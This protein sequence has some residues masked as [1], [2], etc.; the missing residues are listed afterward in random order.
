MEEEIRRLLSAATSEV[1]AR[2]I[3]H[4]DTEK[5]LIENLVR[6]LEPVFVRA[7][8]YDE[9]TR[10]TERK[11]TEQAKA[12]RGD[13]DSVSSEARDLSEGRRRFGHF[14]E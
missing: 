5:A 10:Q 14:R 1:A 11:N 3:L 7:L 8:R 2:Y 13:G 4:L 9:L 12:C 6:K